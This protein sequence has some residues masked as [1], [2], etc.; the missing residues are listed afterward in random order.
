[1]PRFCPC[2]CYLACLQ[3]GAQPQCQYVVFWID[4]DDEMH[5]MLGHLKRNHK[6]SSHLDAISKSRIPAEE[7]YKRYH[8]LFVNSQLANAANAR[9][10]STTTDHDSKLPSEPPIADQAVTDPLRSQILQTLASTPYGAA[11]P[12]SLKAPSIRG[13]ATHLTASSSRPAPSSAFDGT[14]ATPL[15]SITFT[16]PQQDWS[17]PSTI[18]YSN[19]LDPGLYGSWASP[20]ASLPSSPPSRLLT[21]DL[22][23]PYES[24]PVTQGASPP[25]FASA[26]YLG[27]GNGLA[28]SPQHHVWSTSQSCLC[29][30]HGAG[31]VDLR[32]RGCNESENRCVCARGSRSLTFCCGYHETT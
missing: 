7:K 14:D 17:E 32:C 31:R 25:A 8:Q 21:P 18:P 12:S 27:F 1:M 19:T 30:C 29:A 28:G 23:A 4:R 5:K 16:L 11:F 6:P 10:A 22:V 20:V 3:T 9:G 2:P 15:S 24:T 26:T 13:N